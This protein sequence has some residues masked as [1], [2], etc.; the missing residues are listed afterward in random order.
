MTN[1]FYGRA[2]DLLIEHCKVSDE[3]S[4]PAFIRY[5]MEENGREWRFQGSLGFGGKFW[6][7]EGRWY[8]SCYPEDSTREIKATIE[9]V[10]AHLKGLTA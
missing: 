9:K 4:R 3:E 8:I 1:D 5:F 2:Y 7:N 10:N 6:H